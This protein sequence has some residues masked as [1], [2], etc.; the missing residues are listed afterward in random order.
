MDTTGQDVIAGC[1]VDRGQ[2]RRHAIRRVSACLSSRAW[3][4]PPARSRCHRVPTFRLGDL[5]AEARRI[6]ESKV[7]LPLLG[8]A[9]IVV[10]GSAVAVSLLYGLNLRRA[11]RLSAEHRGPAWVGTM[12]IA[13]GCPSQPACLMQ[14][15]ASMSVVGATRTGTGSTTSAITVRST[16]SHSRPPEAARASAW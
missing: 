10:L 9:L 2:Y 7:R 3:H 13:G 1:P 14:S 12:G 16:F 5:A 15:R 11:K 6:P 8:G 4:A